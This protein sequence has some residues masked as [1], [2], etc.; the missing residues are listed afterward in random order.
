VNSILSNLR[1]SS[2]YQLF[3]EPEVTRDWPACLCPLPFL[4]SAIGLAN[5]K[6]EAETAFS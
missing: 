2:K 3:N 6:K 4:A 1:I 5:A